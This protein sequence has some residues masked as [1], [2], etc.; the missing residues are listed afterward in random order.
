[1]LTFFFTTKA[2]KQK[3]LWPEAGV[4]NFH[5]IFFAFFCPAEKKTPGPFLKDGASA[6]YR[7]DPTA[8]FGKHV[9][10]QVLNVFERWGGRFF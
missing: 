7:T 5:S 3:K 10:T 1:M 6:F 9:Y 8:G 4:A 2:V